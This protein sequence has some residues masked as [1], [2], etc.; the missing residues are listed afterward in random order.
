MWHFSSYL[1]LLKGS[2]PVP[3]RLATCVCVRSFI[4]DC[5][6]TVP[7]GPLP[8]V[9]RFRRAWNTMWKTM[10]NTPEINTLQP[11]VSWSLRLYLCQ[12]GLSVANRKWTKG[13]GTSE[14]LDGSGR[15]LMGCYWCSTA[16]TE[17]SYDNNICS[18]QNTRVSRTDFCG[19]RWI[20]TV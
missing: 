12:A 2:K 18:L 5:N 15:S 20:W 7:H 3:W 1:F 6:C 4:S 17:Q 13:T 10:L 19:S 11:F 9:K 8:S 14:R 16:T